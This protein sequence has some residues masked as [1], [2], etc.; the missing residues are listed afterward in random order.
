MDKDEH[1]EFLENNC[2]KATSDMIEAMNIITKICDGE[3]PLNILSQYDIL[4]LLMQIQ[5]DNNLLDMSI[6]TLIAKHGKTQY[7]EN[8]YEI[9]PVEEFM[10]TIDERLQL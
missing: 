9:L 2:L 5:A 10:I 4:Q 3:A 1:I 7:Y 6:Q 8:W